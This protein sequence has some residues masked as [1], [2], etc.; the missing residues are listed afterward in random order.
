[1]LERYMKQLSFFQHFSNS[2]MQRWPKGSY[3][4]WFGTNYLVQQGHTAGA[5]NSPYW[6]V[7][8]LVLSEEQVAWLLDGVGPLL[9]T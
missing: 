3:P 2:K 5:I 8:Q 7:S 1:M 4:C 6:M 9:T